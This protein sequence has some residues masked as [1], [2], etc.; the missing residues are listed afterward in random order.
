MILDRLVD[1]PGVA[2]T[3]DLL[4]AATRRTPLTAVAAAAASAA[5]RHRLPWRRV[6]AAAGTLTFPASLSTPPAATVAARVRPRLPLPG[7]ARRAAGRRWSQRAAR[8][9]A[10]PRPHDHA[11][12]ATLT[13][14]AYRV[15]VR[16]VGQVNPG[17]GDAPS[18]RRS[19]RRLARLSA[20]RTT[21]IPHASP[22][23]NSASGSTSS[24]QPMKCCSGS[25]SVEP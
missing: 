17:H 7:D 11:A 15:D 8:S 21:W 2:P 16:L 5:G 22:E 18:A 19:R 13:P 25:S 9:P 12:A 23:A 24:S 3:G 4:R 1:R 20:R 14:G 6:P 10:A